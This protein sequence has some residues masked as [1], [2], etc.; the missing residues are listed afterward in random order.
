MKIEFKN[1]YVKDP[2]FDPMRNSVYSLFEIL[3]GIIGF[4]SFGYLAPC[5]AYEYMFN[6]I[7]NLEE[8]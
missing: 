3:D 8:F 2:T 6:N 7:K 5:F 4:I 1:W